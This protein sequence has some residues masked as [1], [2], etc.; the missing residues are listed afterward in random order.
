MC[1]TPV[2]RGIRS[3][4]FFFLGFEG[5]LSGFGRLGLPPNSGCRVSFKYYSLRFEGVSSKVLAA[6]SWALWTQ[7]DWR[8]DPVGPGFL[9]RLGGNMKS[10]WK[11]WRTAGRNP[12][13]EKTWQVLTS[14]RRSC[15][16]SLEVIHWKS[17][18]QLRSPCDSQD[19]QPYCTC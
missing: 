16:P 10:F 14:C 5:F 19:V 13:Q 7:W 8:H 4:L 17:K 11:D 3:V 6:V 1:S 15:V 2:L 9:W 12:L 18:L